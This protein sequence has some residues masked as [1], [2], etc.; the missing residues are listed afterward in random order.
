QQMHEIDEYG[1]AAHCAYKESVTTKLENGQMSEELSWFRE[2]IQL[3]SESDDASEF[4]DAIK[5]DFF[6]DKVYVFTPNGD[7]MELPDGASTLDFA[8]HVHTEVGDKSTGARVN[9]K[10]VPL[11]YK[12]KTGDIVEI[13]TLASSPG[14]SRDW[15]NFVNT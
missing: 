1:V 11:N 4:M 15:L 14:P 9:G 5:Q 7:V 3:Q 8:Y 13:I 2:I 12:L 10:I 6:T